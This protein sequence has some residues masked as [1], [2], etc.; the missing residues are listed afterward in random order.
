MGRQMGFGNVII[1][2]YV[3][4]IIFRH[5]SNPKQ[6]AAVVEEHWHRVRETSRRAEADA[7]RY[8]LRKRMGLI[9]ADS[10]ARARPG[11]GGSEKQTS[12]AGKAQ[13]QPV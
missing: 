6:A 11:A 5:V 4:K 9:P 7:M 13:P 10:Q 1:R 2:T 8:E 3:G 12:F